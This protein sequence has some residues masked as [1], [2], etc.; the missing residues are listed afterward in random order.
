MVNSIRNVEY[1]II[2][3]EALRERVMAREKRHVAA[4]SYVQR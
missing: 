4:D 2:I 3:A 1:K